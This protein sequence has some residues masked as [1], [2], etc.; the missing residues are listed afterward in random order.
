MVYEAVERLAA[1]PVPS[2]RYQIASKLNALGKTHAELMWTL[3][4][5]TDE[6][7]SRGVLP[8]SWVAR[9]TAWLEGSRSESS[10]WLYV[11]SI[12]FPTVLVPKRC[13][14]LRLGSSQGSTCGEM[15]PTALASCARNSAARIPIAMR[16]STC[17]TN[18]ASQR[19]MDR[20]NNPTKRVTRFDAAPLRCSGTY[21]PRLERIARSGTAERRKAVRRVGRI[22][23]AEGPG[24]RV[25][26]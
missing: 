12:V 23:S 6:E 26:S 1:D 5:F 22:G 9:S 10:L 4:R 24:C 21:S 11:S 13:A 8:G 2:V 15:W 19:L 16:F 25:C 14:A 18:S 17:C 3:A 7:R 20:R